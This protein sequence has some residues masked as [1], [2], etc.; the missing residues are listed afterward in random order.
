MHKIVVGQININSVRKKLYLPM[1]TVAGNIDILLVT[2]TKIDFTFLV[3]QFDH[4]G[5]NIPGT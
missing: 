1:A 4:N 2:E 3:N 5:Y